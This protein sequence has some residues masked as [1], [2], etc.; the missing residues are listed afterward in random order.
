MITKTLDD[1][2]KLVEEKKEHEKEEGC[3]GIPVA[4]NHYLS[5]SEI[6]ISINTL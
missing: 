4:T 6:R 5:L 2:I 1:I 3:F